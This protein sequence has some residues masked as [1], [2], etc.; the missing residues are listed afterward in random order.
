[1][2]A[3]ESI[4]SK[5]SIWTT[6][7]SGHLGCKFHSCVY[8]SNLTFIGLPNSST[9]KGRWQPWWGCNIGCFT[10]T[11]YV[12]SVMQIESFLFS[13]LAF[14]ILYALC[15]VPPFAGSASIYLATIQMRTLPNSSSVVR[16]FFSNHSLTFQ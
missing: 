2:Y 3:L 13:A 1:M 12:P 9:H 10:V 16:F 7:D 6:D 11:R 8:V 5:L 14:L 4:N 15:T